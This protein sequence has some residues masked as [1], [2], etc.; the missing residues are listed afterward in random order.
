MTACM[1][2]QNYKLS[3]LEKVLDITK[4]AGNMLVAQVHCLVCTGHFGGSMTCG[5]SSRVWLR[6][7]GRTL[8]RDSEVRDSRKQKFDC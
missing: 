1:N 2:A 5:P 4:R 6:A 7:A 8:K 3:V